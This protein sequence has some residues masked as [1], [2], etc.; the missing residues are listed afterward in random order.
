M[1][2]DAIFEQ[3]WIGL[4]SPGITSPCTTPAECSKKLLWIDNG[5]PFV[6]PSPSWTIDEGLVS[7]YSDNV[8][9]V[10]KNDL[11]VEEKDCTLQHTAICQYGCSSPETTSLTCPSGS[12][13]PSGYF[14][15]LGNY[16][17]KSSSTADHDNA[18]FNCNNLDGFLATASNE[19]EYKALLSL[20][21]IHR[22]DIHI[23]LENPNGTV[24]TST[25]LCN[26]LL[27]WRQADGVLEAFDGSYIYNGINADGGSGS[28]CFFIDQGSGYEIRDE[29]CTG[30]NKDYFCQ[31][32]CPTSCPSPTVIDNA[33]AN[34]TASEQQHGVKIR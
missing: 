22:N 4:I 26:D 1:F 9:H 11:L 32:R 34:G 7:D 20:S 16:Y 2:V 30:S 33:I 12:S 25:S 10:L 28:P 14:Y 19:T 23:G 17:R 18:K 29:S 6:D 24:C 15:L 8:C 3:S 27:Y 13:V 31:F 21:G 5:E